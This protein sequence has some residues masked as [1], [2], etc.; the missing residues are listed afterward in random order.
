MPEN[1]GSLVSWVVDKVE[2]DRSVSVVY[3]ASRALPRLI[4]KQIETWQTEN[5]GL[6]IPD[7]VK[8]ELCALDIMIVPRRQRGDKP[9]KA[10][11]PMFELVNR[12][13]DPPTMNIYP[14]VDG[15][16]SN[17]PAVAYY[18]Q[19]SEK[20]SNPVRKARY[21]DIAWTALSK[22]HDREAYRYGIQ[23]ARS[24]L[25]QVPLCLQQEEQIGLVECVDRAAE[26]ALQLN[27]RDPASEVVKK[28]EEI[29][30]QL[31]EEQALRWVLE[32]G[33]TLLYINHKFPDLI[34]ESVWNEVQ[35]LADKGITYY[36]SRESGGLHLAQD[37]M[38]L[39]SAVSQEQ[40]NHDMAWNYRLRVGELFEKES[41][42]REVAAG[43]TG[44]GLVAYHFMEEA[45]REY[46]QLVS[47]A[48]NTGEKQRLRT[49]VEAIKVEIRR[50]MRLAESQ[51]KTIE[52]ESE[53]PTDQLEKIVESL[54]QVEPDH[55]LRALSYY[56]DMV[57]NI[58]E[59]R[60]HADEMAGEFVFSSMMGMT[61]LRDG[62]KV[63]ENP[64][65]SGS[66][67]HF[68]TSLQIWFQVH[69]AVL[70]YVF[71]RLREEGLL[72][73]ESFVAHLRTWQLLDESDVPFIRTGLE[74]YFAQDYT[75]SLHVLVARIEH[76]LKSA[77][78]QAGEPVVVVPNT[79]QIREQT[80]GDFLCREDVR[81]ALGEDMWYYFYCALVDENH[82]N[83][84]N[85]VAHGWIK[86]HSCNRL[87]VQVV[88]F[89][90]LLL[91][92]LQRKYE[93]DEK[94]HIP[95]DSQPT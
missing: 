43:V 95:S 77:F 52:V 82:L 86:F 54:L 34:S 30:T 65:M 73:S 23:A 3:G 72:S 6:D 92:R 67:T 33:D 85:D 62:R 64:P 8:W 63:D 47:I 78:E 27:N 45:L 79:N 1:A 80:L 75:S 38:K 15:L 22:R 2:S 42:E 13:T 46:Q 29:L 74:R 61:T 32:L 93:E 7:E 48:P 41:R 16:I 70:D 71:Q 56:P 83:L 90:I 94:K 49:K 59:L 14:D 51:M 37:L 87:S 66:E 81:S 25:A 35:K 26:I 60:R 19:R 36:T 84:R 76:M 55:I 89:L 12:D 68:R 28:V 9:D 10:L 17:E 88:L 50:L 39:A 20:T 4:K 58:A 18:S 21:A 57:P 44:G 24:Y 69:F 31:H 11:R 5:A 40:E 53:M 91:T